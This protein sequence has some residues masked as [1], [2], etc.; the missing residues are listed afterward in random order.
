MSDYPFFL[1]AA[2]G[3]GFGLV[4][5]AGHV[6]VVDESGQAWSWGNN[7]FG[8]LGQVQANQFCNRLANL[9]DK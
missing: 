6:V 8:Q 4:Q 2:R 9:Y 3:N 1:C 7:E 5:D